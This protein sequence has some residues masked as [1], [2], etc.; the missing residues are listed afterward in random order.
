MTQQYN[1]QMELQRHSRKEY[2]KQ[3]YI[4]VNIGQERDNANSQRCLN[5]HPVFVF[6]V[7]QI[8]LIC[9]SPFCF[10]WAQPEEKDCCFLCPQVLFNLLS[11]ITIALNCHPEK[12]HSQQ[13]VLLTTVLFAYP[14]YPQATPGYIAQRKNGE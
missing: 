5:S 1:F 11:F 12:G 9:I 8:S 4:S 2:N 14:L 7:V 13:V 6:S 3:Q 10:G